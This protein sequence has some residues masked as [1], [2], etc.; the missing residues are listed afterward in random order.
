[1]TPRENNFLT[2]VIGMGL[3]GVEWLG[4]SPALGI[5]FPLDVKMPNIFLRA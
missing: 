3:M 1:M 5:F 4:S 2:S